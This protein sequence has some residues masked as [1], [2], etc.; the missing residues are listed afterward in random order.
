MKCQARITKEYK[1]TK[2]DCM[3]PESV[4]GPVDTGTLPVCGGDVTIVIKVESDGC[5]CCD[6]P[7]RLAIDD[8]CTKCKHPYWQDKIEWIRKVNAQDGFDITELLNE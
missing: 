7:P 5:C 1:T 8:A 4:Y 3:W 6:G 2:A